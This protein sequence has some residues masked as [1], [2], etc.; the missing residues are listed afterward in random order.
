MNDADKDNFIATL[1]VAF[2]QACLKAFLFR[3]TRMYE[4]FSI[5]SM[6]EMFDMEEGQIT[7]FASKMIISNQL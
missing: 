6:S 3:A 1:T 2:K 7:K 5:S 4:S